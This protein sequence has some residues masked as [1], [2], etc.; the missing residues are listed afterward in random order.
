MFVSDC[1]MN[2]VLVDTGLLDQWHFE[3][4]AHS[5]SESGGGSLRRTGASSPAV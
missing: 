3:I 5:G 4:G 1:V 2:C